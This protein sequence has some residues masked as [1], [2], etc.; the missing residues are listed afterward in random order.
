MS[1]IFALL[2]QCAILAHA[3]VGGVFL[4]FSDVIMRALVM[5]SGHGG[6]EAMQV[7]NCE[8]FR[9]VFMTLFLGMA[10]VSSVI[11]AYGAFAMTGPASVADA[12]SFFNLPAAEMTTKMRTRARITATIPGSDQ[13]VRSTVPE[14]GLIGRV[15]YWVQT[16][17]GW[18]ECAKV[19]FEPEAAHLLC[20]E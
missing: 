17:G 12:D 20:E 15:F 6:V 16:S 1:T 18:A 8:V 13:R 2:I 9:W 3:F 19:R 14:P 10:V 4:A 5:T 11:A 7:I